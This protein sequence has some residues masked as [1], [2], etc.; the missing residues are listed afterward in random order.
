ME[1]RSSTDFSFIDTTTQEC[2]HGLGV[3]GRQ[4]PVA[5][6]ALSITSQ[7]RSKRRWC[8][9]VLCH[10]DSV[11]MDAA[12]ITSGQ[13]SKRRR[14]DWRRKRSCQ[15]GC[16]LENKIDHLQLELTSKWGLFHCCWG[17][18]Q[19]NINTLDMAYTTMKDAFRAAPHPH[20]GSSDQLSVMLI[21]AYKP[22]L[23]K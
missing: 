12:S 4:N 9:G 2:L 23:T 7:Q 17:F 3:L 5:M 19:A 15:G 21:P 18:H 14:C 8:D 16:F 11:A 20:L 22:L 6:D 13:R 10:Q 1:L